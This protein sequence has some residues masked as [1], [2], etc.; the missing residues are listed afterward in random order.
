MFVATSRL[1]GWRARST[2]YGFYSRDR[3]RDR[4]HLDD[5][6][7]LPISRASAPTSAGGRSG[8]Q[9]VYG[10]RFERNHTVDPRTR[11]RSVAVRHRRQPREA[12]RAP[13]CWTAATTRSTRARARSARSRSTVAALFLGSD[14]AEPQAADA[15]V[16]VRAVRPAGAGVARAGGVRVRPDP[17]PFTDRFRAGGGTSVRGYG[18]ESLGPRDFNG[19]PSG[20]DR[21]LI[22]NQEAALPAVSLGQRRRVRRRRQHPCEGRGLE[23]L[24][25]RL[26]VWSALRYAGGTATRRPRDS[27]TDKLAARKSVRFY[28]GFGH[29]F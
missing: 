7:R 10:Y 20:G 13:C 16:R 15:A 25:D 27:Q 1:F 8:F 11:Q 21:L 9:I 17:L 24:E 29:I 4:R 5:R 22:L 12:E 26:R 23:R 6:S 19:L 3:F 28:F 14:V 2:L 18:E